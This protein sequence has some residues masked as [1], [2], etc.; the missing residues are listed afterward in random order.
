MPSP[1][2]EL[3]DFI[4]SYDECLFEAEIKCFFVRG[5]ELQEEQIPLLDKLIEENQTLKEQSIKEQN[6]KKA[7]FLLSLQLVVKAIKNELLFIIALK[8]DNAAQAWDYLIDAQSL[9]SSSIRYNPFNGD[10]LLPF[11]QKLYLYEKTLFPKM[12]FGS[13]GCVV[14][15]AECSICHQPYGDCDHIKG[16]AYMGEVCC[17]IIHEVISLEEISMVENPADKR[18]RIISFQENGKEYDVLTQREIKR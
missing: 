6:E 13:R 4:A 15:K 17:E 14:G 11:A 7:N 8:K 18:C 3:D 9:I 2:P 16:H 1:F 12:V 10:Y 5:I